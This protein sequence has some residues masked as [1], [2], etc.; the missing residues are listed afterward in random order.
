MDDVQEQK[1]LPRPLL[2]PRT[3]PPARKRPPAS[4]RQQPRAISMRAPKSRPISGKLQLQINV[5]AQEQQ[6]VVQ[7]PEPLEQEQKE[8]DAGPI[9]PPEE[10]ASPIVR[11]RSGSLKSS[12]PRPFGGKLRIDVDAA[13]KA[14]PPI[15]GSPLGYYASKKLPSNAHEDHPVSIFNAES[16]VGTLSTATPFLEYGMII[17]LVCDDRGGLVAAEGFALRDVKLE[18]LNYGAEAPMARLGLGG[19]EERRLFAEGGFRLVACPYRDCLFEVVPKMTYDATIALRSLVDDTGQPSRRP[20]NQH[21][22]DNLRFK[23]EAETRLNAMMYKKLKGTQVIY[24]QT[25]QL[26]HMKS[27]KY[28]SLDPS[29]IPFRG[30]EYAPMPGAPVLISTCSRGLNCDPKVHLSSSQIK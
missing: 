30:S 15:I 25:I 1:Q 20:G 27:G 5:E 6:Q 3:P 8:E 24:G 23:S 9:S 4:L 22:V 12:R 26:R 13:E 17:S 7:S 19:M 2:V 16:H 14:A 11:R 18:K 28:V 21:T 29:P 10:G